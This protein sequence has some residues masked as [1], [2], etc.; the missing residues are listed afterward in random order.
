MTN[1]SPQATSSGQPFQILALDGGGIKGLFS[2]AFLAALEQDLGCTITDH[3]DL[4]AG[5]STGGIIALTLGLGLSPKAI[6]DFYLE[7]GPLI[8]PKEFGGGFR[9]W[10]AAKYDCRPLET[11]LRECLG[12]RLLSDSKKRLVIP[13]FNL[14]EDDVYIFRTRHHERLRR[15]YKVPAWKIALATTAAPTYFPSYNGI[16]SLRL[17]D[18]GV[19]ANNPTMVAIVEA[20][21][22]LEVS[23]QTLRVL[24]IGTTEPVTNRPPRLDSG[25]KIAWA[26]SAAAVEVIMQGQ[27]LAAYKQATHLIGA[28][29]VVRVSPA[30]AEGKFSL[31]GVES[32]E[33]LIARASHH[34]RQFTPQF[35]SLF[36]DHRAAPFSSLPV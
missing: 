21:S 24:N 1:A 9:H 12:D 14:G 5:T 10:F 28:Q 2:A 3:F 29:N 32:S 22:T 23:L 11:A 15:D 20:Y 30:V 34:S 35:N 31:D 25:G 27:T 13:S 19:W 36:A 6:L 7:K 17:V 8:F 4:I 18:G 33:D 26:R 16:D